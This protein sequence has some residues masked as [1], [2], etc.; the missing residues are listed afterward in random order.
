MI[1]VTDCHS[2][3]LGAAKKKCPWK[4][5]ISQAVQT[6]ICYT[7]LPIQGTYVLSQRDSN[8]FRK[9]SPC[10]VAKDDVELGCLHSFQDMLVDVQDGYLLGKSSSEFRDELTKIVASKIYRFIYIWHRSLITVQNKNLSI[11]RDKCLSK[12]MIIVSHF[13]QFTASIGNYVISAFDKKCLW[14]LNVC[15][16]YLNVYWYLC[17]IFSFCFFLLKTMRKA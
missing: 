12:L 11:E 10:S 1:T 7:L 9:P 15:H 8:R 6:T 2:N 14:K 13:R 4:R 3:S 5:L 17:T 16:Y